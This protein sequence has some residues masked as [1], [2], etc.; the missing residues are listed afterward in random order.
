M[1]DALLRESCLP[2]LATYDKSAGAHSMVCVVSS[3]EQ[4]VV[5]FLYSG[6]PR[7]AN[8]PPE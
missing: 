2:R 8:T 6:A 1:L 5:V 7:N 3:E 4:L